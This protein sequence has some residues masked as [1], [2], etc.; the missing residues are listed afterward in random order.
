MDLNTDD[1]DKSERQANIVDLEAVLSM[2]D[3]DI[4]LRHIA[5]SI[6]ANNEIILSEDIESLVVTL[7]QNFKEKMLVTLTQLKGKGILLCIYI[8]FIHPRTHLLILFLNFFFNIVCSKV[9]KIFRCNA[10]ACIQP[11]E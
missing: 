10:A 4:Q 6:V 3:I 2:D 9:C 7:V 1:F 11:L 5:T 8:P